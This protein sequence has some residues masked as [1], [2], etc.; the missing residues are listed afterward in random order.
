MCTHTHA[1]TKPIHL[2][3]ILSPH[4][5]YTHIFENVFL[6]GEGGSRGTWYIIM[7]DLHFAWQKPTQQCKAIFLQKIKKNLT[8]FIFLTTKENIF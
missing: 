8:V 6:G 1:H 7:A 2:P 5:T 4:K 3:L